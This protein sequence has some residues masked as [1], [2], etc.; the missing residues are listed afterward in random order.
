M[1]ELVVKNV[2]LFGDS[3]IAAK[4]SEGMIWA[5]VKWLCD[6]M[7]LSKGQTQNE[8]MKLH[9]DLVLS[10]GERNLMLPT[11]GGKQEVLCIRYDFVPLWVAKISITP[12][13]KE[14]NPELVEKLVRYQLEAKDV[15]VKAFLGTE[16]KMYIPKDFPSALRAYADEYE[17]NMLLEQKNEILSA[18]NDLLSQKN[19]EWADR[20][21]INALVRAY[22]HGIGDDYRK[23]WREFKKELLYRYGININARITN[24][25]NKS[26]KLTKPRTLDMLDDSELPDALSTITAMCRE[27]NADISEIL[28]KKVG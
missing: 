20:A 25:L 12:S 3:I 13:M 23:A 11:S 28:H 2:D 26:G 21:V 5:A 8:R 9:G 16:E 4:D 27:K 18:E 15:L 14:N 6:G 17:K 22:A 1:D 19:L 10:K 24:H 7:G